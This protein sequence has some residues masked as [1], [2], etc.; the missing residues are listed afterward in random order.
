MHILTNRNNCKKNT[1][2]TPTN[3]NSYTQQVPSHPNF[4][5]SLKS[6]KQ[7]LHS[8]PLYPAGAPSLMG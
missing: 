7:V 8:D 4:M 5:A 6:I 1:V 2:S 3:T